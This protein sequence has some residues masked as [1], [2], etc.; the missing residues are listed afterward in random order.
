MSPVPTPEANRWRL[1]GRWGDLGAH[2]LGQ[3]GRAVIGENVLQHQLQAVRAGQRNTPVGVFVR[4]ARLILGPPV[5]DRIGQRDPN[6]RD[7]VRPRYR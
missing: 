6:S 1:T 5:A 3:G 7:G 2:G 4:G